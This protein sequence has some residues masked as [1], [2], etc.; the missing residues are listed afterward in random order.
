MEVDLFLLDILS[1]RDMRIVVKLRE[2]K[3]TTESKMEDFHKAPKAWEEVRQL[4][5]TSEENDEE[6]EETLVHMLDVLPQ[7][8]SPVLSRARNSMSF[9]F[10]RAGSLQAGVGVQKG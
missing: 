8:S 7:A 9:D 10:I 3:L 5:I 4:Q 2:L 1:M 6:E